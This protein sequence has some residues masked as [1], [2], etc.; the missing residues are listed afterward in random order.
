MGVP[1]RVVLYAWNPALAKVAATGALDRVR[2][3]N[4]VLSDYEL[5]S[6]LS[7]LRDTAG[8]GQ[9]VPVS[10]TLWKVLAWSQS[11]AARTDGAFDVTV[12]PAVTLWRR[13]RRRQEFPPADILAAAREAMGYR[14]LQLD[15]KRQSVRLE[16]PHMKLDLGG[17]AK[18]FALDEAMQVLKRRGIRHALLTGGGDM[19]M[20]EPP[21]GETGWRIELA[22]LDAPDAP[23]TE[24]LRLK[25]CALATSGDLFQHVEIDGVRYSHIVDPRTGVGLTDHSLVVVIAP[26]G[27]QADSLAT[28]V[29]VLGPKAG[30]RLIAREPG[31]EAQVAR[32]P[33]ERTEVSRSKGFGAWLE[34]PDAVMGRMQSSSGL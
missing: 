22:P 32:R 2:E 9:W 23:P 18:G 5:E 24:F 12:G 30:L 15:P 21:P 31:V 26:T 29:S 11:L 14:N 16:V 3:L 8:T 13:A 33:G 7:R 20:S 25:N 10:D 28:T 1:F 34:T 27:L 6:E 4:G 17:V 19:L